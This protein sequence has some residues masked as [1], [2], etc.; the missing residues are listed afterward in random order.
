[1]NTQ[2]QLKYEQHCYDLP[3]LRAKTPKCYIGYCTIDAA[4][5]RP[6]KF[7]RKEAIKV[8]MRDLGIDLRAANRIYEYIYLMDLFERG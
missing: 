4:L 6:T 1:M 5:P 2:M 8:L 7:Y 3:T